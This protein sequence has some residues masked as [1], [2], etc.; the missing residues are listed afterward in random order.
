MRRAVYLAP[1]RAV[2]PVV[3]Q[4]E[5]RVAVRVAPTSAREATRLVAR[6]A[7]AR[8]GCR[9]GCPAGPPATARVARMPAP[10]AAHLAACPVLCLG[11]CPEAHRV[12]GRSE[13]PAAGR[14]ARMPTQPTGLAAVRRAPRAGHRVGSPLLRAALPPAAAGSRAECRAARMPAVEIQQ[15]PAREEPAA[16]ARLVS[17]AGRVVP[18]TVELLAPA[19]QGRRG[20]EGLSLRYPTTAGTAVQ[21]AVASSVGRAA[22]RAV[23]WGS[24]AAP[25]AMV[26]PEAMAAGRRAKPAAGRWGRSRLAAARAR[27]PAGQDPK[28]RAADAPCP[29]RA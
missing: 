26:D 24:P 4:A 20:R 14:A 6:R 10:Q 22:S 15:A 27:V 1:R 3:S 28:R 12:L 17:A 5:W 8:S 2:A 29:R 19:V 9:V 11:A 16:A 21:A 7:P 25:P 23:E 13:F 18:G